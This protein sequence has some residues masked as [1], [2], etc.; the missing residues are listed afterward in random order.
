MHWQS[1]TNLMVRTLVNDLDDTNYKYSDERINSTVA[2]SAQ[3]VILELDFKSMYTVDVIDQTIEPDPIDD[4][5]FIN[6]VVYRAAILIVG[7]EVKS[8]AANAISIKDGPS[9]IDLR[10]VSSTLLTLYKYL[11]DKYDSIAQNYGYSANLGNAILGPYSPG[12]DY[13][14][15]TFN[16]YDFRGNYF[17]N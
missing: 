8:E 4:N 12:S 2:V 1:H 14:V 11:S 6:L 13:I 5:V 16:D 15:R 3:L 10:G 17:R 7:G 9:A